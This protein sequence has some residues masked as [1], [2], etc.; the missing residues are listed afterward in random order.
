MLSDEIQRRDTYMHTVGAM[1]VGKLLGGTRQWDPAIGYWIA[2]LLALILPHKPLRSFDTGPL[3]VD[4][5]A[6]CCCPLRGSLMGLQC[7]GTMPP[8]PDTDHD[9]RNDL[10]LSSQRCNLTDRDTNLDDGRGWCAAA[11]AACTSTPSIESIH[12][13]E[14]EEGAIQ[15]T[16]TCLRC[17][18]AMIS[19]WPKTS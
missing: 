1:V 18:A 7:T 11:A 4:I 8:Y 15:C 10:A 6:R 14:S 17:G 16:H 13:G 5:P 12:E 2:K 19:R 3:R 9:R